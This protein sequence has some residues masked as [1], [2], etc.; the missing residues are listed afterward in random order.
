MSYLKLIKII[1]S[2]HKNKIPKRMQKLIK[3]L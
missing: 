1:K 3:T 2:T